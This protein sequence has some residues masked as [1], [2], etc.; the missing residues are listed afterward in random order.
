V[1]QIT[2]SLIILLLL[3]LM[4]AWPTQAQVSGSSRLDVAALPIPCTLVDEIKLDTPCELTLLKFD[5]ESLLNLNITISGVVLKTDSAIGIAGPEHFILQG[6]ATLG[7]A[8]LFSELWFAVPFESVIDANS[9]P[10]VV[11]IPP[12]EVMFVK[13]RLTSTLNVAGITVN[14]LAMFE[15][16]SFPSPG[17]NFVPL[18]YP[19]QSQS[20]GFGDIITI[21]GQTVSGISITSTTGICAIRGGNSVKK[22][23]APGSV[24][25][26]CANLLVPLSFDFETISVGGISIANIPISLNMT[27]VPKTGLQLGTGFSVDFFGV[28][29]LSTNF[30]LATATGVTA[31][32]GL[33][34]SLVSEALKVGLSFDQTF[35]LTSANLSLAGT[36]AFG[37]SR[38]GFSGSASLGAGSG[39]S[40]ISMRL[41]L[42][43]GTFSANQAVSFTRQASGFDQNN[44]PIFGLGFGSFSTNISVRFPPA[45]ITMNVSFGKKGLSRFAVITGVVF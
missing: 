42:T 40:G 2:P 28:G 10:N 33:S 23:S 36:Q 4:I 20:F 1:F 22:F 26:D 21:S 24:N 39:L 5:I 8:T 7:A 45:S 15:D 12:G 3:V 31:S 29:R 35:K 34:V 37:P 38:L 25:P 9:Q 32:S 13:K 16:V 44:E 27:A 6:I 17:A 14:N 18:T 11:V 41:S 30:S 19:V 43:Q